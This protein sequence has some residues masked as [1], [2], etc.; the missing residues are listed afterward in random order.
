[1]LIKRNKKK[2]RKILDLVKKYLENQP[3]SKDGWHVSDLI[4]PRKAYFRRIDPKPVTDEEALYFTGGR[5][6]HEIIEAVIGKKDNKRADSGENKW[7]GIYYSPDLPGPDEIK[8]SR[9]KF[10][11]EPDQYA[12]QYRHYL[13]QLKMYMGAMKKKLGGLIVFYLSLERENERGTCPAIR[14]YDVKC[15]IKELKKVRRGM[16]WMR[17]LLTKAVKTKKF[18]EIPLCP[19]WLCRGCVYLKKCRPW[20]TDPKRKDLKKVK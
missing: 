13:A 12:E 14:C 7:K 6:H 17:D 5:A 8:T 1:M 4:F 10:E 18:K 9:A 11:P 3:R 20:E 16:L 15:K 2:E 19:V